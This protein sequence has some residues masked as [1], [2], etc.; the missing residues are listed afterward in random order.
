MSDIAWTGPSVIGISAVSEFNLVFPGDDPY[1]PPGYYGESHLFVRI[2]KKIQNIDLVVLVG[3][4]EFADVPPYF[5]QL[6]TNA[7]V[8]PSLVKYAGSVESQ[9]NEFD[10]FVNAGTPT[11]RLALESDIKIVNLEI[12][13]YLD[14]GTNIPPAPPLPPDIASQLNWTPIP[15]PARATG[16]GFAF[17]GNFGLTLG[18]DYTIFTAILEIALGFDLMMQQ[19]DPVYCDDDPLGILFFYASGQSYASIHGEVS[20]FGYV[21]FDVGAAAALQ[22]KGSNPIYGKGA[23]SGYYNV[24]FGAYQGSCYYPFEIGELCNTDDDIEVQV[25]LIA[26]LSPGENIS[27][28]STESNMIGATYFPINEVSTIINEDGQEVQYILEVEKFDLL[29]NGIAVNGSTSQNDYSIS[30]LSEELLEEQSDYILDFKVVLR[31]LNT[32]EIEYSEEKSHFF[33]TGNH[34]EIITQNN[35]ASTWPQNGQFNFYHDLNNNGV[36]QL[37]R[38]QAYLFPSSELNYAKITSSYP[39]AEV[40]RPLTY[41]AANNTISFSIPSSLMNAQAYRVE[42]INAPNNNSGTGQIGNVDQG[43]PN[44]LTY[45]GGDTLPPLRPEETLLYTFHF[46]KSKFDHPQEKFDSLTISNMIGNE[47]NITGITEPFG[48]EELIGLNGKQNSFNPII[49]LQNTVFYDYYKN[50]ETPDGIIHPYLENSGR[51]DY[52]TAIKD[53]LSPTRVAKYGEGEPERAV[54]VIQNNTNLFIATAAN[55]DEINQLNQQGVIY[56]NSNLNLSF[57]YKLDSV[58]YG[59]IKYF[60]DASYNSAAYVNLIEYIFNDLPFGDCPANQV[61]ACCQL[62]Q[63]YRNAL[64]SSLENYIDGEND[65]FKGM[66]NF[67]NEQSSCNSFPQYNF[68]PSSQGFFRTTA[69]N[70]TLENGTYPIFLR[71]TNPLDEAVYQSPSIN[72]SRNSG[73][74]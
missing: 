13:G 50:Y 33:T 29:K 37:N 69:S 20:G 5:Q 72:I 19:Y 57:V 62:S 8:D 21:L 63:N 11:N 34:P 9:L 61:S 55:I 38:D 68:F 46:R 56:G 18:G 2:A 10:W 65:V 47:M 31:N 24:A 32:N 1:L 44:T 14:V 25:D 28:V 58:A 45:I 6:F 22:F 17:G 70:Y 74:D 51:S 4:H 39:A 26:D 27:G 36:I 12:G 64:A 60:M 15:E 59:D 48:R 30:F 35:V 54:D 3:A 41:D 73:S 67:T 7:G 43:V 23:I 40:A 52:S 53:N 49:D 42:I 71:Y 66:Y 16:N